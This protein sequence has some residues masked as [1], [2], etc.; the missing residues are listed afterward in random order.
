MGLDRAVR[1]TAREVDHDYWNRLNFEGRQVTYEGAAVGYFYLN[2]GT[3]GPGAW[4]DAA[5]AGAVLALACAE[6]PGTGS[7][8]RLFVPG[9]NHEAI[10]FALGAGLKFAAAAHLLMTNPFGRMER[11]LAS[12]PAL[13]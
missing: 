3:I 12:G 7:A 10:R 11:Y 5:H 4:A 9:V 8:V 6:A 2:R 1:G 13:F